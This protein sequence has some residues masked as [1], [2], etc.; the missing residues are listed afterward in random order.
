VYGV[1]K[2]IFVDH[3][4]ERK[5]IVF[6]AMKSLN[7]QI[8]LLESFIPKYADLAP[9]TSK[10]SV[11][12]HIEHSLLTIQKIIQRV[13]ASDAAE[14]KSSYKFGRIIVLGFRM[15]PRGRA[16]SPKVVVPEGLIDAASL[17]ISIYKTRQLLPELETLTKNQHFSH[18]VLGVLNK[19]PM[20]KFLR[21][22]T[23][24]H[25]KIIKDIIRELSS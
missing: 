17:K 3:A 25:L 7:E 10:A 22:H 4:I 15:I 19:K 6:L 16:Q 1:C 24:H 23:A 9:S 5:Y 11:G 18:P 8:D 12:W 20:K 14:Y 2:Y 13:K 21:V